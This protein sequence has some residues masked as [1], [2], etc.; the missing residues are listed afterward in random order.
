MTYT[1]FMTQVAIECNLDTSSTSQW[2]TLVRTRLTQF[3]NQG[4]ERLWQGDNNRIW[5]WL[6][7]YDTVPAS[8]GVIWWTNVGNSPVFTLW[9]TDPRMQFTGSSSSNAAA[10]PI[11]WVL[12][13]NEDSILAQTTQSTVDAIFSIDRPVFTIASTT[14]VVPDKAVRWMLA[15]IALRNMEN[16]MPSNAEQ[17]LQRAIAREEREWNAMVLEATQTWCKAPWLD[18]FATYNP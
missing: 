2:T 12:E 18:W 11:P 15:F 3:L 13:P 16:S 6:Q 7:N 17:L 5:P 9:T 10:R 8:S 4:M 14:E 1:N